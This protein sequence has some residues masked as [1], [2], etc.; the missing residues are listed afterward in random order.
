MTRKKPVAM[1]ILIVM[2]IFLVFWAK[3]LKGADVFQSE[4]KCFSGGCLPPSWGRQRKVFV[5]YFHPV[6]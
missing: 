5:S 2:L 3:S 4:A 6:P 1:Q